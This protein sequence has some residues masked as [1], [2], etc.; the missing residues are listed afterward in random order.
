MDVNWYIPINYATSTDLS[1][2]VTTATE[3][4]LP[5]SELTL[6]LN[7]GPDD[8]LIINK[9]YGGYYRT[10]YDETNWKLIAAYLD[11]DDFENIP[12]LSR[13]GLLND[14]FLLARSGRLLYS[15][16]LELT[17]YLYRETDYIVWKSFFNSFNSFN[18]MFSGLD[19]YNRLE[20]YISGFPIIF[21]L[22]NLPF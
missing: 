15:V 18:E 11:T 19:N 21:F 12:P 16:A 3:W 22:F 13:A 20:V 17:T 4:I 9:E 7:L 8:L 14:A 5:T 2:D 10:N 6:N 1:F